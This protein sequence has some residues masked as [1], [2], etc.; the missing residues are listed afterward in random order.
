[1]EPVH[2]T[3]PVADLFLLPEY[4]APFAEFMQDGIQRFARA[5]DSILATMPRRRSKR[6]YQSRN[7]MPSGA[8]LDSEPIVARWQLE[9]VPA[10]VAEGAGSTLMTMLEGLAQSYVREIT[11][12][13]FASLATVS[14]AAGTHVDA[15][16]RPLSAELLAEALDKME[17]EFDD[18]GTPRIQLVVGP[19]MRFPENTEEGQRMIDAVIERKRQQFFAQRRH[20]QLPDH[21][22]RG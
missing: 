5:Q 20:R 19:D 9:V 17:I 16:G 22:L 1:L 11:P 2:S 10:D 21:P 4:A 3:E 6:T 13:I 18:D 7:S 15:A 8:V 14:T 12:Q